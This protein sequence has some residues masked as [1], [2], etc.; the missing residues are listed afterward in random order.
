MCTNFTPT[1]QNRWGKEKLGVELPAE[2]LAESYPV[3]GP[4]GREESPV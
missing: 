1:K 3:F 4:F 2:Y